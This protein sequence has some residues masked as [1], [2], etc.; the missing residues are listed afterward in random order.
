MASKPIAKSPRRSR[1]QWAAIVSECQRS[2]LHPE[3]FCQQQRLHYAT[4]RRWRSTLRVAES[5]TRASVSSSS[6]ALIELTPPPAQQQRERVDATS[7]GLVELSL[8]EH[9]VLRIHPPR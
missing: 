3:V 1:E 2:G 8:G 7:P 5:E 9:W 4:F 6:P